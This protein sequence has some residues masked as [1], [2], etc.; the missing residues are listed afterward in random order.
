MDLVRFK[1]ILKNMRKESSE[2]QDSMLS[3]AILVYEFGPKTQK[4]TRILARIFDEVSFSTKRIQSIAS[5]IEE[6]DSNSEEIRVVPP[7]S[8]SLRQN[9]FRLMCELPQKSE[10]A[11]RKQIGVFDFF[12]EKWGFELADV[13][14]ILS[15]N[16]K[17]SF[18]KKV[19]KETVRRYQKLGLSPKRG[20][21]AF[22]ED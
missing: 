12:G 5:Y 14:I 6:A 10:Y 7:E 13:Y 16:L 4:G 17:L 9:Y 1:K 18:G 3:F 22:W 8:L 21:V 15:E 2:V 20:D 19:P 11:T